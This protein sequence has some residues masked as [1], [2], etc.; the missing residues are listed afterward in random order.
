M[1]VEPSVGEDPSITI[2]QGIQQLN[3]VEKLDIV[4]VTSV[5]TRQSMPDS[6]RLKPPGAGHVPDTS[7]IPQGGP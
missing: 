7:C 4:G 2:L 1:N 6:R 3:N 5:K